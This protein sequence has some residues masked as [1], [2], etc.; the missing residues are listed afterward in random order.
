MRSKN[1]SPYILERD[2][3]IRLMKRISPS[4]NG[5]EY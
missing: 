3:L 4:G 2:F 5:E 1:N